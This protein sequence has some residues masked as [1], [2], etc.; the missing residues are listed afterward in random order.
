MADLDLLIEKRNIL[1]ELADAAQADL[2][3]CEAE[4]AE[5]ENEPDAAEWHK[6]TAAW[7]R[8]DRDA[9]AKAHGA[10]LRHM[11]WMHLRSGTVPGEGSH[12]AA[13]IEQTMDELRASS[14]PGTSPG[15]TNAEA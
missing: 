1:R 12:A 13:E 6:Q 8:G 14:A 10:W 9:N 2:Q 3:E 5:A 7:L 15:P 4:I 11:A